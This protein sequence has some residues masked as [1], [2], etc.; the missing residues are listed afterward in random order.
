MKSTKKITG[1][2]SR[3]MAVSLPK[4]AMEE[5]EK[6]FFKWTRNQAHFLK[7]EEFSR[8]DIKHLIEEIE[9]LGRSEK[10]MLESYLEVLLMHLLKVKYQ[11]TKHTRSWD[12]SIKNSRKKANKVLK[13]N[14]SLKP[15]LKEIINSAYESAILEAA[16]ETGLDEK[17][18]PKN[19]PWSEKELLSEEIQSSE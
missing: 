19:C 5:Y 16:D 9:S 6:D 14:S 4:K 2:H 18:F 7:K 8:L 17:K 1:L 15:K 11:P 13:E 3:K 12:L 10:R